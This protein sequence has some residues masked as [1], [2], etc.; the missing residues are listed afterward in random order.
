MRKTAVNYD[1]WFE[2]M[3]T[4]SPDLVTN[5]KTTLKQ[6]ER[7]VKIYSTFVWLLSSTK[8]VPDRSHEGKCHR[9]WESFLGGLGKVSTWAESEH[10]V[11]EGTC[12]SVTNEAQVQFHPNSSLVRDATS[13]RA[14]QTTTSSLGEALRGS[15]NVVM[16]HTR[17]PHPL[18]SR[19]HVHK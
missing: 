19:L 14:V 9:V 5:T 17:W 6:T 12:D 18:R 13:S 8:T 16:Q 4:N 1:K 7:P 2:E 3:V 11:Q 10:G 15:C